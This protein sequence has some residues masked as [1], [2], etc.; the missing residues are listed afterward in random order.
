MYREK[1]W[2]LHKN[3]ARNIGQVLEAAPH[4][5]AAVWPPTPITKIIQGR[6]TRHVGHYLKSKDRLISDILLWTY[7][8]WLLKLGQPAKSYLQQL[9]ANTE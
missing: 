2:Q 8:H 5:A 6:Q 1:A 3:A 4:K 9:C 7:S